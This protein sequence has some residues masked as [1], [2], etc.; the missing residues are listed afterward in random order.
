[1]SSNPSSSVGLPSDLMANVAQLVQQAVSQAMASAS[2]AS[3]SP[4]SST[5]SAMGPPPIQ[6]PP[7]TQPPPST[8]PPSSAQPTFP[9]NASVFPSP[10]GV[11]ACGS[12]LSALAGPS[13]IP[14]SSAAP[15]TPYRSISAGSTVTS[16]GV[17]GLRALA[18]QGGSASTPRLTAILRQR[19][20][21]ANQERL[22]H[23]AA[24]RD[25]DGRGGTSL[26][27]RRGNSTT[28]PRR[29][30]GPA[31]RRPT[32]RD[33]LPRKQL[34]SVD[35]VIVAC[36]DPTSQQQVVAANITVHVLFSF[37]ESS[38]NATFGMT[39][40]SILY[41]DTDAHEACLRQCELV[42]EH[43]DP[44]AL[45]TTVDQ[46]LTDTQVRMEEVGWIFQQ[47]AGSVS[48]RSSRAPLSLVGLV[49]HG[50]H[51]AAPP[52]HEL[53]R[54]KLRPEPPSTTL[55]QLIQNPYFMSPRKPE[56]SIAGNRF[57]IRLMSTLPIGRRVS[58]KDLRLSD[59]DDEVRLH[60][61]L[62]IRVKLAMTDSAAYPELDHLI[63]EHCEC[64]RGS[65]AN[66]IRPRLPCASTPAH[67][68]SMRTRTTTGQMGTESIDSEAES[69]EVA[70]SLIDDRQTIDFPSS[71]SDLWECPALRSLD[72][73][74]DI[75]PF[76]LH[77]LPEAAL[78][79]VG[80]YH[81]RA[82]LGDPA[83]LCLRARDQQD[84]NHMLGVEIEK[85][86]RQQDYSHLLSPSRV[87]TIE[88]HR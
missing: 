2:A 54:I 68:A 85:A 20:N 64:D 83:R 8:Q 33:C 22:E 67:P 18:S 39:K 62:S 27:S 29:S 37:I 14:L 51:I 58:L 74:F 4:P 72:H 73:D 34:P 87:F 35:D 60:W 43:H 88:G 84:M 32:L 86:M 28:A 81:R 24:G 41:T 15:I 44:V 63:C 21:D 65:S 46:I 11:G 56:L 6:P 82:G 47:R 55:G 49:N 79:V 26:S 42:F 76:T 52:P 9:T 3:P 75:P 13:A 23:S 77:Q 78:E 19:I 12:V 40:H 80:H 31:A 45:E 5:N 25:Q 36:A 38:D 53:C 48:L 71:L 50:V 17:P 1:M 10:Q 66:R 57:I 61:C 30:R 59:D 70:R 7:P 16:P 69:T